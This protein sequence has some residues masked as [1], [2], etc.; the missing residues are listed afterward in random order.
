MPQAS[1]PK[2][3]RHG[4]RAT[5]SKLRRIHRQ[6]SHRVGRPRVAIPPA[7]LVAEFNWHVRNWKADT[8]HWSSVKA[9]VAH[10]SY[11]RIMGMGKDG[12]PLLFQELSREPGHWLVALNAMTGLDPVPVGATFNQA[13]SAWLDW[14]RKRGY[15]QECYATQISRKIFH[16]FAVATIRLPVRQTTHT[17]A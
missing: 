2:I 13:V 3:A 17:T 14:G 9:M 1:R 11:R 7:D 5:D 6:V 4:K 8:R 16:D 12:L 10:P 15:L